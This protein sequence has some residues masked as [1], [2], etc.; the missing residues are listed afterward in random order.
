MAIVHHACT[1]LV[2]QT[3]LE[4][5]QAYHKTLNMKATRAAYYKG[6]EAAFSKF[7]EKSKFDDGFEES[8]RKRLAKDL[9]LTRA[10]RL[11]TKAVD[12]FRKARSADK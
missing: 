8:V 9:V 3:Q 7:C 12:G 2:K 4:A 11:Y 10:D 1:V 5:N 6:V